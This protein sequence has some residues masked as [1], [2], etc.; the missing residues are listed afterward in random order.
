[1]HCVA[2]GKQTRGTGLQLLSV[3]VVRGSGAGRI[4]E[5]R[6][7]RRLHLAD[8]KA[9]VEPSHYMHRIEF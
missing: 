7:S 3:V 5:R 6:A 2:L 4:G 1:M 8:W 9:A